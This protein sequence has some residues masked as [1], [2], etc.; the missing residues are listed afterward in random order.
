ME[1]ETLKKV[2]RAFFSY[3][4]Y[5]KQAVQSTVDF[6]EEQLAVDYSKVSVSSTK[7]N[8][9]ETR[10]CGIIDDNLTVLK[11]CYVVEKVLDHYRFEQ[12]KVKFI[13]TRFFE[14]KGDIETCL[15]VGI[16]RRTLFN[17]QEEIIEK[18]YLWAQE[19][20]LCK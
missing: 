6:A 4:L 15:K 17:W 13:Q 18:G 14:R 19:K 1:K 9:K 12:D 8:T 20:G 11:W 7:S 10:L 3:P 16:C 2:K 5:R